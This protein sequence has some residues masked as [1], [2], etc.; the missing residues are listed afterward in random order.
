M[1]FDPIKTDICRFLVVETSSGSVEDQSDS[2]T[3]AK[4]AAMDKA[5]EDDSDG[6]I[7]CVYEVLGRVVTSKKSEWEEAKRER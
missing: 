4:Q 5:E 3:S 7:F 1:S 6:S 2:F